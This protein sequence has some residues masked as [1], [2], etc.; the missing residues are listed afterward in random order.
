MQRPEFNHQHTSTK[1]NINSTVLKKNFNSEDCLLFHHG[2]EFWRAY[3]LT[4]HMFVKIHIFYKKR[5]IR[6]TLFY[7]L[8]FEFHNKLQNYI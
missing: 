2:T 5:C 6:D 7:K 8:H 1:K 3:P 4:T